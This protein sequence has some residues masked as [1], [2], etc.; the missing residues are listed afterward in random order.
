MYVLLT[1]T[2][3]NWS[4]QLKQEDGTDIGSPSVF[5]N[6]DYKLERDKEMGAY[7]IYNASQNDKA[8]PPAASYPA[9]RVV[10]TNP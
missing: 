3:D 5:N 2:T 10:I 9:S 8:F 4:F 7:V 1:V 6:T